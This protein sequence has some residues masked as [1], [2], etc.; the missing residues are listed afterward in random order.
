[1]VDKKLREAI[2][3]YS[4]E[5]ALSETEAPILLDSASY[6]ASIVGLTEGNRVVYSFDSMVEELMEDE[7]WTYEEAVEWLEYNTLRAIPYMGEQAPI[8]VSETRESLLD[9]Y[10]PVPEAPKGVLPPSKAHPIIST[11]SLSESRVT[12]LIAK[13][14]AIEA[15]DAAMKAAHAAGEPFG[16]ARGVELRFYVIPRD[17][18]PGTWFVDEYL[19]V[20]YHGGAKTFRRA[21]ANSS[22]ANFIEIG[23]LLNGGYYAEID[24]VAKME[25]VGYLLDIHDDGSM[26]LRKPEK[27]AF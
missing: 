2:T 12:E 22:S 27:E 15:I 17:D 16:S 19:T 7:G 21:T 3:S 23:R 20:T 26:T 10:G 25:E 4:Q 6:D 13:R 24:D 11:L 8:I 5:M 9:K 14:K 1:M 18:K